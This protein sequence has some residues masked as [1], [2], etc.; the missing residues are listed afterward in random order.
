MAAELEKLLDVGSAPEA[1]A[2]LKAQC[3]LPATELATYIG[4]AKTF[5]GSKEVVRRIR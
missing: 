2:F 3:N 1:K 4:F 5:K